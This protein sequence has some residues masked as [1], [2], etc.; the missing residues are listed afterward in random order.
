MFPF[1]IAVL[2]NELN[3]IWRDVQ[4]GPPDPFLVTFTYKLLCL[5]QLKTIFH[6]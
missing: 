1:Q 5:F 4:R 6:L 3:N 2:M